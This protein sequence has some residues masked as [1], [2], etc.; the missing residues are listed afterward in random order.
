VGNEAASMADQRRAIS[1][2]SPQLRLTSFRHGSLISRA[3]ATDD[4]YFPVGRKSIIVAMV[5]TYS[6]AAVE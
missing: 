2:A 4:S 6:E 3:R 1:A 5:R